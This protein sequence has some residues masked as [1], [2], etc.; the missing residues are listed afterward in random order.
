MFH[1]TNKFYS[2]RS[3]LYKEGLELLLAKGYK[4]REIKQDE[5]YH[6]LSVARK[7]KLLSYLAV[8]KFE[9]PQYVLFQQEEIERYIADFLNIS[10]SDS[11]VVLQAIEKQ[12]GLLI[13][14]AH[15]VWSFSHLT[16]QEYFVAQWF[17]EH[18][19][20]QALAK[21]I[22]ESRYNEVFLLAI[23]ISSHHDKF[24]SV[25]KKEIDYG[26]C[27]NEYIQTFLRRVYQK[28]KSITIPYHHTKLRAF[29]FE[30]NRNNLHEIYANEAISLNQNFD[31]NINYLIN[32]EYISDCMLDYELALLLYNAY[33]I[34]T[35]PP[36][37]N[38]YNYYRSTQDFINIYEKLARYSLDQKFNLELEYIKNLLPKFT[39]EN[40]Q[41]FINWAVQ[42]GHN[43]ANKLRA[44]IVKYRNIR[45][46]LHFFSEDDWQ[47]LDEYYKANNLLI[48]CLNS[49]KVTYKV[50]EE[51]ID[52]LL[53]PASEITDRKTESKKV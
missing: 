4:L 25:I 5:I 40:S 16:F 52:T 47:S 50:R 3:K 2:Q 51:I 18:S 11:R 27:K 44:S 42:E 10:Q 20:W 23:E 38:T 6:N 39:F 9:Q 26:F 53:L 28:A 37:I 29:Y 21:N 41:I 33:F 43:W 22:F 34:V 36:Y 46:D 19:N 13:P 8:K 14:R 24:L 49:S 35:N 17:C 30:L 32:P 12:H 7:L 1:K 48:R 45:H 15:K 31:L